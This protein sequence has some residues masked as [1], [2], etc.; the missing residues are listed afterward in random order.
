M[1]DSKLTYLVLFFGISQN[2]MWNSQRLRGEGWPCLRAKLSL[3]W[4]SSDERKGT[5]RCLKLH[6]E[7]KLWYKTFFFLFFLG[8]EGEGEGKLIKFVRKHMNSKVETLCFCISP[9]FQFN[10]YGKTNHFRFFKDSAIHSVQAFVRT[11][12]RSIVYGGN[13]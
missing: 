1:K 6:G 9:N 10:H 8:G 2:I 12:D 7:N 3:W 4:C 5:F 11:F 13:E